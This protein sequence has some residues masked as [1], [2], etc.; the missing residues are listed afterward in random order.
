MIRGGKYCTG[1]GAGNHARKLL[2]R[3]RLKLAPQSST[4]GSIE[5]FCIIVSAF[6]D[7]GSKSN[8]EY[9]AQRNLMSCK[10]VCHT[11]FPDK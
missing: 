11:K 8:V 4:Y 5:A 6:V 3:L 1:R 7:I 2:M 9:F 10:V